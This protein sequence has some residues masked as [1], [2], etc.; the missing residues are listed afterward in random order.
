[1]APRN[2]NPVSPGVQINEIDNS[3]RPGVR[4]LDGPVVIGRAP[5]GPALRPVTIES[6]SELREVFG[7]P[8][9]LRQGSDTWRD[10]NNQAPLYAMYAADAYLKNQQNV[11]FVRLL[12]DA[13]TD[14]TS[15]GQ[16]G[17]SIGSAHDATLSTG[18]A[19]GLFLIDSG[20]ATS[21]LTGT[22]AAVWYCKE[23]SV[24]LSG[25]NRNNA[26]VT[27]TAVFVK[28]QGTDKE[29]KALVK[30]S[31]GT[32][33]DTISFNFNK[34]S[35][36]FARS[37]F[38]TNPTLLNTNIT[39]TSQ[40][41]TYVLGET[42]ERDVADSVSGS[43]AGGQLGV[44]LSLQSGTVDQNVQR[45][46]MH[47]ARTGWF[48]PQDLGVP[49]SYQADQLTNLFRFIAHDSGEWEQGNLKVSV[50]NIKASNSQE[51]KYGSFTVV[52]R[53]AQD[54]DNAP[55]VLER[56]S[57]CNLN[58]F[59]SNF[60]GQKIGDKYVEW[61]DQKRRFREFGNFENRSKFLR[62]DI[63]PDVE[64]GA[65]NPEFLPFGFLGPVRWKGFTIISGS[66]AAQVLGT[67]ADGTD[68]ADVYAAGGA[69]IVGSKGSAA[70]FTDV[71]DVD[72]TGSFRFP[73]VPMRTSSR[74]GNLAS[75]RQA[76]FGISTNRSD[77]TRH[78]LGYCDLVRAKPD[79]LE[80][81]GASLEHSFVFS[82]DD[83]RRQGTSHAQWVSGSRAAGTSF[84]AATGTYAAVLD[85][86]FDKFT[87]PMVGGFDGVD[88]TEKDPFNNRVLSS[89]TEITSYEFNSLKRALDAVADPEVVDSTELVV[90]GITNTGITDHAMNVAENRR[91]TLA[92]IDVEGGFVPASENNSGDSATANR[93]DVDTTISNLTARNINNSYA[94]CYYPWVRLQDE[95][96][97]VQFWAPPSIVALGVYGNTNR[98]GFEWLAP[99]G[100]NRGGLSKG[101]AGL[102][103][104][105][106]RERLDT[107]QRDDLYAANINPIAKFPNEG[108]VIYGQKTL[109]AFP[110]ALD[111]VNVRRMVNR[112]KK[113]LSRIASDLLFEQNV[114]TTWDRFKNQADTYLNS[115]KSN[116][117]LE[118]FKVVLDESTTTA[119]LRDR[120]I[121]YGKVF[122]KPAKAIEFFLLDMAVTDSGASFED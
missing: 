78:E 91:D 12:G 30:N 93:G 71:G 1:M 28:S 95:D 9:G 48:I 55:V 112:V 110:S 4:Q 49:G 46:S 101:D 74:N 121:V 66:N 44:V 94:T 60:I 21:N 65:T 109:Q 22:L 56:F 10:G 52:V 37:V 67:T 107:Q 54:S 6:R 14:S 85:A 100:F 17:W 35:K 64:A 7:N 89:Q 11:T 13:H 83:L 3:K 42:Y 88:I 36:K 19:F 118:D 33:V 24:E 68:F 108:I 26:A 106:V 40:Q 120:N 57:D 39:N 23:G 105:G 20:S 50:E 97:G 61:D 79:L 102:P 5:R 113:E 31:A 87:A 59:S 98:V 69:S 47:S 15:A 25:N 80:S 76:Y 72:F 63:N 111:R 104:I 116:L 122:L 43:T 27:G 81:T 84:T 53:K 32:I 58:P 45:M 103:V 114:Q 38:N 96:T 75:P 82:L 2:F 90:P 70:L 115:V 73:S 16:A 99:A 51:D 117:G 77:S 18:G 92:I 34:N 86:G 41:K 8:G 119:D 29:F 62:V